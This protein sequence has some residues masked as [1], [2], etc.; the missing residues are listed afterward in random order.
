MPRQP[1]ARTLIIA[2]LAGAAAFIGLALFFYE[3]PQ[4]LSPDQSI[5]EWASKNLTEATI[6]GLTFVTNL[7]GNWFIIVVTIV[8]AAYSYWRT[9][10]WPAVEL[11]VMAAAGQWLISNTVKLLVQRPRPALDPQVIAHGSS[12]PSGH[13]SGA[14]ATYLAIALV[15][16][17]FVAARTR[18]VLIV[19]AIAVSIAV[20]ASRV[21]LGV[22]WPTDV[23]GGLILGW[24]WCGV[25]YLTFGGAHFRDRALG[26]DS[27]VSEPPES[28]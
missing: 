10:R 6:D 20:A 2:V 23:I 21:L 19:T 28:H 7:A 3:R 25:C 15:L 8:V 18:L 16:G 27:L 11:L 26:T 14:A 13:S 1:A 4:P 9:R 17:L 24:T 12:F 22:H 5:A